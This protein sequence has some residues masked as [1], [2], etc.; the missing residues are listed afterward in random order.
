[1][2]VEEARSTLRPFFC[3]WNRFNPRLVAGGLPIRQN[4]LRPIVL[5]VA[6]L[7]AD[8]PRLDLASV[9]LHIRGRRFPPIVKYV[10]QA[11]TTTPI[12]DATTK[13][14]EGVRETGSLGGLLDWSLMACDLSAYLAALAAAWS[15]IACP[16]ASISS[17]AE[18][19]SL[20][21]SEVMF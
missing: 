4:A 12:A 14:N 9:R 3:P 6:D 19:A 20:S 13:L 18:D 5:H 8:F 11:K 17:L 2:E 1:M 21:L 16:N 7:G 15:E 10:M